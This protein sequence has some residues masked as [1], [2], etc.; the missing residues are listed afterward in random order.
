MTGHEVGTQAAYA[1]IVTALADAR[2]DPATARFDAEVAAAVASGALDEQLARTLRWWQR[3]S[4]R[5][6]RDHLAEVLP[7]VLELMDRSALAA[8]DATTPS[9]SLDGPPGAD[10]TSEMTADSARDASGTRTVSVAVT[11]PRP[12]AQR[13]QPRRRVLVASLVTAES[14]AVGARDEGREGRR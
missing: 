10:K 3:E 11:A 14:V 2:P 1:E 7:P 4:V 13:T 8:A 5:G 12:P 6:V 9:E